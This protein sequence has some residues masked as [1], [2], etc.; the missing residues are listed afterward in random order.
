[1]IVADI[2]CGMDIFRSRC[3]GDAGTV[4]TVNVQQEM[5]DRTRKR[6]ERAGVA[7]R[8]RPVLAAHDDLGFREPRGFRPGVL[9]GHETEDTPRFFNQASRS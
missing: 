3:V 7:R 6:A 4:I 9:D 5:L 2:G 8:I 1:M